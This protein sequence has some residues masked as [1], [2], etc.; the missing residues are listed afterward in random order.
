MWQD[1]IWYIGTVVSE[2][3]MAP[4]L[5]VG[6]RCVVLWCGVSVAKLKEIDCV[7]VVSL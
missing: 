1:T 2:K 4:F 6:N 3:L 7:N 5:R